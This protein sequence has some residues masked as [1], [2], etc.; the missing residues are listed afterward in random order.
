MVLIKDMPTSEKPRERLLSVGSENLSNEELLSIIIGVGTK[1]KSVK[2]LSLEI[3]KDISDIN[4]LKELSINKL[5]DIKGIGLNKA[6]SLLASL[7]LGR[8]V[9]LEKN[10]INK[11]KI[12]CNKDVYNYFK[13]KLENETQEYFYVI[14]LDTKKY[15]I[16][17]KML[18]KGTVNDIK[19]HPREIFKEAFKLSSSALICIHNHPSGDS[20][21]SKKDIDFTEKLIDTGEV[22][23]IKMLDHI[24][25]GRKSYFSFFEEGGKYKKEEKR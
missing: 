16:G 19:V 13:H 3:L 20:E 8:R 5:M 11:V 24:I 1:N 14:Y 7:E 23:G 21:P 6:I 25:I 18:F 12:N 4:E 22:V 17:Q 2:D 15:V 9:Y 10:D